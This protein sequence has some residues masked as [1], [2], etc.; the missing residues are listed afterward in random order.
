MT[1]SAVPAPLP[2]DP[3]PGLPA[4][5]LPRTVPTTSRGPRRGISATYLRLEVR[6]LLR[7]RRTLLF[8]LV[9][10]VVFY[11]LFGLSQEEP[12]ARAYVM[13]SLAV[14]GGMVAATSTGA[15]VAVERASGWSRQLRLTPLPP[16]AHVLTKILTALVVAALPVAVELAVGAVSG[17][18][19]SAGDWVVAGLVA[20]LGSITFAAFGLAMGYLLPSENTMQVLG[21]LLAVLALLGGLF[22]PL[23]LLSSTMQ[24]VAA[25]TPA[26][27][28]GVLARHP[29]T[30]DGS[31]VGALAAVV[32]WTGV[33]AAVAAVLFRRDTGR[34]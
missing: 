28:V 24:D 2:Q 20:W 15:A 9:M 11:C 3:A 26:F 1:A 32:V 33:F 14:Y 25:W 27:G 10:P 18:R 34:V 4:P 22:V 6:R 23:E 12:Q 31:V 30:G 8:T 29:L 17:A 19:M 7:N 5:E 21:P 16:A 13:T